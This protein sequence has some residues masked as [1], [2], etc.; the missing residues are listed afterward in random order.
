ME[1]VVTT[2]LLELWVVQNSSQIIT[3]NKLTSSFLQAGCPSCRQ[4]ASKHLRERKKK[5]I[6]NI[7]IRSPEEHSGIAGGIIFLHDEFP[8][9]TKPN[10]AKAVKE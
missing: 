10:S 7:I 9:V 1:V 6:I 4:T 3:I 2:G 8:P 5:I